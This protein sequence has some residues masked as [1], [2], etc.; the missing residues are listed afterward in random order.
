MINKK[1]VGW[2]VVA[3]PVG[4]L[5]L[6]ALHKALYRGQAD[7]TIGS[8][9]FESVVATLAFPVVTYNH[10]T[11]AN[12][13]PIN[14]AQVALLLLSGL[15]WGFVIERIAHGCQRLKTASKP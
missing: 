13:G 14:V 8:V 3:F 12:E 4:I 2:A 9:L 7:P 1:V 15:I 10:F 5:A 11:H 6:D